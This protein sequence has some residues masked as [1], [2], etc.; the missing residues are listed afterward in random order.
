LLQGTQ[1]G[2]QVHGALQLVVLEELLDG[3]PQREAVVVIG[4]E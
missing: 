3:V 1:V 2:L 4:G